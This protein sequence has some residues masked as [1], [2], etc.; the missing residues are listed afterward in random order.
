MAKKYGLSFGS[1]EN[2]T[3]LIVVIV[4]QCSEKNKNG[5]IARFKWWVVLHVHKIVNKKP[6]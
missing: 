4:S 2:I 3:K 6:T 5:W 1:S